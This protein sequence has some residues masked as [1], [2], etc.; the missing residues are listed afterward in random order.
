MLHERLLFAHKVAELLAA[1]YHSELLTA[2]LLA[3]VPL[4]AS[5]RVLFVANNGLDSV[6]CG[7]SSAPCRS[8]TRAIG[9]AVDGDQIEV[10]AGRYGD[11][12]ADGELN[13]PGEEGAQLATDGGVVTV[14]KRLAIYSQNGAS[15]T[16]IDAA[17]VDINAQVSVVRI[18]S[19]GSAFGRTN[20]GFTL[21]GGAQSS[22][23]QVDAGNV[24]IAG[25]VALNN[26]VIGFILAALRGRIVASGN[27]AIGSDTAGFL[28]R[29]FNPADF[30]LLENNVAT[31][32]VGVGFLVTG[33]AVRDLRL[34]DQLNAR[35]TSI[36]R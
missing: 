26:P 18:M 25:N 33:T 29:G 20:G 5:G 28:V 11:L 24:R 23:M 1:R 32:N 17:F 8:I 36:R 3:A 30:V 14:D 31:G 15:A 13:D 34:P 21:I 7:A 10:R 9:N 27:T 19:D 12:N 22:G 6:N 4:A 2:L 16:I 35:L